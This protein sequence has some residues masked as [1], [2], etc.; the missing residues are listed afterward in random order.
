MGYTQEDIDYIIL[1]HDRKR[2][3]ARNKLLDM[4]GDLSQIARKL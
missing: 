4:I 1:G 2:V 3:E